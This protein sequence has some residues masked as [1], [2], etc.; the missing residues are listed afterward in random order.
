MRP[1]GRPPTVYNS[2]PERRLIRL[3]SQGDV[4]VRQDPTLTSPNALYPTRPL[5]GPLHEDP[6]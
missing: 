2:G 6:R 1:F 5:I 3:F 4:A